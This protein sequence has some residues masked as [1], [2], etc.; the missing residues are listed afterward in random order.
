MAGALAIAW[1]IPFWV[2][3]LGRIKQWLIPVLLLIFIALNLDAIVATGSLLIER[4][5]DLSDTGSARLASNVYLL[6]K[7]F[8]ITWWVPQGNGEFLRAYGDV[9]HSNMT[10]MFMEGGIFGLGLWLAVYLWPIIILAKKLFGRQLDAVAAIAFV[11]GVS[12]FIVQLSLNVPFFEQT[13]LWAGAVIGANAR[14]YASPGMS[15]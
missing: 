11:M 8:D 6:T 12:S 2:P 7:L 13:W 14:A 10:A 9:P 5:S 4:M 15:G 1:A 3:S